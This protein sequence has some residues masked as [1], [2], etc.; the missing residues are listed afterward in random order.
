MNDEFL[1]SKRIAVVGIG[2]VGGYMAGMLGRAFPHL[3]LAARGA[4]KKSI[5]EHGLILHSD[6]S[7]EIQIRPE[8][9]VSVEEM[10][11]QDFIFV[12][13]KNYSLEEV[14]CSMNRA[15]DDH[16]V[17]IPVMNGTNPGERMRRLLGKGTVVDSLIYIIAFANEDFSVSQQ[18]DTARLFIGIPHADEAQKQTVLAVSE[19]LAA[20]G[21]RH[22]VSDDIEQDIWRK[23]ILNCAYNVT[24]A[25]Y[26]NTIGEIRRDPAKAKEYESLVQEAYQ[27]ALA[28][29]IAITQAEIDKILHRF[30]YE[31]ADN[32]TS[33]LQRDIAAGR[34]SELEIFSGYL[35]HEA[36]RLGVPVPVTEKMYTEL[37]KRSGKT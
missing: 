20:A 32:A 12:C 3:T 36:Q 13:V 2:G 24:T 31:Y 35:V 33:S 17:L 14:C 10:D 8:H 5:Q 26:D 37:K 19:I 34:Q 9:T 11:V 27:V 6:C 15:V 4:R 7:G 18:G 30:Y 28:R 23:Y 21:I 25:C 1:K 22:T 29:Q 16:T